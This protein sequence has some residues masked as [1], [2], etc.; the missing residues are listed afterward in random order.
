VS[1][2]E[3]SKTTLAQLFKTIEISNSRHRWLH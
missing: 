1:K 3:L 2:L